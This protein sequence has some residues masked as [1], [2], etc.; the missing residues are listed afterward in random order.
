MTIK[1]DIIVGSTT[2]EFYDGVDF[3]VTSEDGF[4]LPPSNL[5]VDSAPLQHGA[6]LRDFRLRPRTIHLG[7]TFKASTEAEHYSLR[8]E[9]LNAMKLSTTANKLR[10]TFSDGTKRQIDF[11]FDRGLSF[12]SSARNMYHQ[13]VA[14]ALY[15]PDPVFYDPV[16][17]S[18]TFA[19]VGGGDTWEIPTAVPHTVGGSATLNETK[20]IRYAGTWR[21]F[22]FLIRLYGPITN[23]VITNVTTNKKLDFTG[24]TISTSDYYEIDLRFGYKTVK[25]K[26]GNNKIADLTN[27]SDLAD[28]NIG[29]DPQVPGGDNSLKVTGS[30]ASE[31]TNVVVS[32]YERYI[33]F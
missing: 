16:G 27:D 33:G 5:I 23:P 30:G 13:R 32:Y 4:G 2:Y 17:R 14:L 9:M 26:D 7:V 28:W 18:V 1:V 3:R 20:Q 22:P 12:P 24:T 19:Q 31:L 21:S 29:A 6:T 11:F 25:D 15:C 8:R 10:Y